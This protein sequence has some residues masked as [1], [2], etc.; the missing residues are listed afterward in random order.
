MD[1]KKKKKLKTKDRGQL[2]HKGKRSSE[3]QLEDGRWVAMKTKEFGW[4]AGWIK[5]IDNEKIMVRVEKRQINN[6]IVDTK[7][8]KGWEEII[9][10]TTMTFFKEAVNCPRM[11]LMP[12]KK[13]L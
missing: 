13:A 7:S 5:E 11:I 8:M 2:I 6:P 4:I 3:E 1:L 10:P 12:F 9:S